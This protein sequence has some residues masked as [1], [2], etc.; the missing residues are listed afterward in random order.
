MT[1]WQPEP[2]EVP[3]ELTTE[4]EHA[5]FIPEPTHTERM[6]GIPLMDRLDDVMRNRLLELKGIL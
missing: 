6:S 5:D 4:F 2:R 3:T 1:D